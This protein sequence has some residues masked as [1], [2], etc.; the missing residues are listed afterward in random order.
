MYKKYISLCAFVFSI[1]IQMLHAQSRSEGKTGWFN[2]FLSDS[3]KV[4]LHFQ[5][6]YINQTK[7]KMAAKYSGP[8]SLQAAKENQNSVTATAF[9]GVK[10]WKGGY[11]FFNPEI[12]GGSGLSGAQGMGGAPNGETF[13]VGNP[14]PTLYIGRAYLEQTFALHTTTET[15]EDE[16]NHLSA[17][18]PTDYFRFTVGKYSLADLF[19]NNEYSN[20]PR[21]Q[22][23]NWGLM[24]NGAWDFAANVRGY[25]YIATAELDKGPLNYKIGIANLPKIANGADINT[26]LSQEMAINAQITG[27]YSIKGQPGHTSILYF[28]NKAD[29]GRY[30]QAIQDAALGTA[31]DVVATRQRG[32][33]KWG[34][35]INIDQALSKTTGLFSRIGFNDGKTETWNF[36]E[37]DQTAN[38]GLNI[39]GD[40]WQRKNDN[41]GAAIVVNGLSN[42]HKNYL[43]NGGSG[44]ILG[45]GKL[46]YAPESILEMYYSFKPITGPL[47]ITGDY[48]FALNPGYNKD[49]G[50]A[51]ILSVRVHTEF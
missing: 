18:I 7:P 25:T 41:L 35:G 12:A 39:S 17:K 1:S 29:M 16:A 36:T 6:T 20:T 22:F 48:Q 47:W 49:R 10:L 3:E 2:D 26:H 23:M 34:M 30:Q 4:N 40:T 46:N 19:D 15:Q 24:N 14:S 44:F 11:F 45:D 28:N 32:R 38:L 51:N 33:H 5:M 43:R 8:L 13:R 50:P 42:D 31:P 9:L 21:T 27:S 37:I